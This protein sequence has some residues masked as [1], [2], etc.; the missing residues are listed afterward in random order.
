MCKV[1]NF[2]AF[3]WYQ[4]DGV[5][6]VYTLDIFLILCYQSIAKHAISSLVNENVYLLA[7]PCTQKQL[8]AVF[9]GL[10]RFTDV[11]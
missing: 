9:L 6:Q 4:G 8:T 2:I 1:E 3:C 7:T 10:T 5:A 11:T